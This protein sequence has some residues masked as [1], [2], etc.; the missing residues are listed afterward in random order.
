VSRLAIFVAGT[1]TDVGKTHVA[2]ALIAAAQ[3]AGLTVDALKPAVSGFDGAD[4]A[5]SDPGRL[6]AALGRPSTPAAIEAISPWRLRAPLAPPLAARL[7][8]RPLALGDITRFCRDQIAARDVDLM[9]VEG[10]G[11]IMSPIAEGATCLDLI[12]ALS[13]PVLLVGGSYLGAISHLLT[14]LE[15]LSVRSVPVRAVVLSESMAPAPDFGQ[16]MEMI[17]AFI[18]RV[19]L[20]AAPRDGAADWSR[21]LLTY[22]RRETSEPAP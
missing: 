2:C 22:A 19:P 16:T 1:H 15:V 13:L 9:L 17:A 18:G 5:A 11:G 21:A 7:E 3:A 10:A 8:G 20:I 12:A 6:L 14:A 4:A